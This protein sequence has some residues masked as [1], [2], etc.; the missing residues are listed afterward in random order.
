MVGG[1]F[2]GSFEVVVVSLGG[3]VACLMKLDARY[4]EA[5][6]R[7]RRFQPFVLRGCYNS[8]V[9]EKKGFNITSFM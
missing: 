2:S 6:Y 1:T 9:N 4:F 3:R 7:G 8:Y 5:F